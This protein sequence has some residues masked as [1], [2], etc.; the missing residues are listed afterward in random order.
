MAASMGKSKKNSSKKSKKKNRKSGQ[1]KPDFK[2]AVAGLSFLLLLIV[3]A[4][5]LLHHLI[6]KNQP[7]RSAPPAKKIPAHKK[8]VFKT[9][10]FEIYPKKERPLQKKTGK[11]KPNY[12]TQLPKVAIIIDDLGYDDQIAEKFLAL[13]TVFTFSVF[14]YSPYQESIVRKAQTK[15]LDIM[16]HLPMEPVEYPMIHPGPGALLTSMSPDQL[17][18]Q[19]KRDLDSFPSVKG[20][21]NHMGSKMTTV[22][23]QMYQ[24]FSILKKR[25]LY[26]IDSRTTPESLCSPSARLLQ[27]PFAQR[28]V[29]L[30]HVQE[31][32]FIRKQIKQL[33][34][35]AYSQGEAVGIAHPHLETYD[36]LR[37]V[38][39][40]LK[41][42]VHLVSASQIVH[43][44][45]ETTRTAGLQD[46]QEK[47]LN[48]SV[49][50]DV[51][52]KSCK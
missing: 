14:P 15:G 25:N 21:N 34:R 11:P 16:L 32:G 1:L 38:L 4:G 19:L 27:V 46:K 44:L 23:I 29:F 52:R 17:I 35:V 48:P 45:G 30:D 33:I 3:A 2:R 43:I 47:R 42:K 7:I 26:F 6:L 37:E 31:D 36:V 24:I 10:T 12:S 39:P 5:F 13:D 9:P 8:P 22:S 50:G 49:E 28:D 40:E 20:V 18:D 51:V 41:K